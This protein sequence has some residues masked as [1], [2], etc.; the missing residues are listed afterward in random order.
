MP[1]LRPPRD[2]QRGRVYEWEE[3][4]VAPRDRTFIAFPG[5]QAMVN[6]IWTELG[7]RY[8]PRVEPLPR[9]ATATVASA[10]RLSVYL[11]P[12]TASWCLL[13]ELAHVLS[14]AED[15]HSDGHGPVFLGLYVQLLVRYM[16][17][18]QTEL[19]T[20]LRGA[21]LRVTPDARPVFLDP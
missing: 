20:S 12:R 8:P 17:L 15:G 10:N 6:A 21:G 7:L 5:A 4:I 1:H 16:R 13:H 2:A 19:L 18:D 9:Q 14:S 3:R 11:P